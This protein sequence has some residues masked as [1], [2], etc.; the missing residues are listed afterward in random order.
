LRR[1]ELSTQCQTIMAS[2]SAILMSYPLGDCSRWTG[3]GT[4]AR[5]LTRRPAAGNSTA[6]FLA[7]HEQLFGNN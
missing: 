6:A 5:Y 3:Q 7:N 2:H 1:M 4:F